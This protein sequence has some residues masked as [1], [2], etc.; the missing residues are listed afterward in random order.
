MF[1]LFKNQESK[2]L[3]KDLVWFNNEGKKKGFLNLMAQNPDAICIAWFD[4]TVEAYSHL[5]QEKGITGKT[6][7]SFRE[8]NSFITETRMVIF[9]EH[10]PLIQKE[11]ALI[12]N[13]KTKEIIFLNAMDEPL[14]LAF[15]GKNIS[16]VA[17]KSGLREDE[18]IEH[19]LVSKA[20]THAREKMASKIQNETVANS[21]AQWF[22]MNL[23]GYLKEY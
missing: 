2:P 3:I 6:I 21:S 1:S 13:W 8:V 4:D 7:Y 22:S 16:S 12:Q 20:L 14:F 17:I 9:L 15:G 19:P 18:A 5:M 11:T 10:Y 23:P